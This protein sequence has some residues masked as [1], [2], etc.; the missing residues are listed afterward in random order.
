MSDAL[1][2]RNVLSNSVYA[3]QISSAQIQGQA[4]ARERATRARQE[5]IKTEQ[6]Q[7]KALEEANHAGVK[8]REARKG[9]QDGASD[10]DAKE[11][12]EED[13]SARDDTGTQQPTLAPGRIDFTA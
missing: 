12:S 4:A 5:A 8:D 3:E 2:L 6:A 13:G 1:H 9:Q 11:R 7:I 10:S